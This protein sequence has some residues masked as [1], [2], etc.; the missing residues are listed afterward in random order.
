MI[1]TRYSELEGFYLSS[2]IGD[3]KP[4][5]WAIYTTKCISCR[6]PLVP[7]L[8]VN[9]GFIAVKRSSS[10]EV[11]I[12]DSSNV[13]ELN[14]ANCCTCKKILERGNRYFNENQC[15]HFACPFCPLSYNASDM[16]NHLRSHRSAVPELCIPINAIGATWCQLCHVIHQEGKVES[17]WDDIRELDPSKAGFVLFERLIKFLD[18]KILNEKTLEFYLP[19]N[20][21]CHA[22]KEFTDKL[23]SQEIKTN[24]LPD[25]DYEILRANFGYK[26][27][28]MRF[29]IQ[30]GCPRFYRMSHYGGYTT[31]IFEPIVIYREPSESEYRSHGEE[32]ARL[33]FI[34][35]DGFYGFREYYHTMW[36]H[37]APNAYHRWS[38]RIKISNT[39]SLTSEPL[40][41]T[42]KPQRRYG[43][44]LAII[45]KE[46]IQQRDDSLINKLG[47]NLTQII[48][49]YCP[50]SLDDYLD[51]YNKI[52]SEMEAN[53][54]LIRKHGLAT[55]LEIP[56]ISTLCESL[57]E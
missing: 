33:L 55:G 48:L 22:C 31:N 30:G 10:I 40:P 7:K 19:R 4:S 54:T 23:N 44:T 45:G 21:I 6:L 28:E 37:F 13:S 41:E 8:I 36:A 46:L 38:Q 16:R 5:I 47:S 39:N 26:I 24:F 43:S 27:P 53:E 51:M 12:E 15:G 3:Q 35:S 11:P 50:T 32:V 9:A 34:D 29:P 57:T 25:L 42:K 17:G 56:P 18:Q 20:K 2:K 52:Y 1:Q 49:T 14:D